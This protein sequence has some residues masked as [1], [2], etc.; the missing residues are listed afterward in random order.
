MIRTSNEIEI[1]VAGQLEANGYEV[2][3]NGWPDFIAIRGNEIRFIEVKP[4]SSKFT[5]SPRQI[6]VA[7]V[8]KKLGLVVE[9]VNGDLNSARSML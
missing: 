3:K 9:I 2:L 4:H 1:H 5:G 8:F 6:K 7:K